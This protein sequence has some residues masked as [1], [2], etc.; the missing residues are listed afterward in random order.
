MRETAVKP[1]SLLLRVFPV[2]LESLRAAGIAQGCWNRSR[3]RGGPPVIRRAR[4]GADVKS[5]A[6]SDKKL[7]RFRPSRNDSSTGIIFLEFTVDD[8]AQNLDDLAGSFGHRQR[9]PVHFLQ[10]VAKV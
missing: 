10:G 5:A 3:P 2:R 4:A 8:V 1:T 7:E 9:R 6:V